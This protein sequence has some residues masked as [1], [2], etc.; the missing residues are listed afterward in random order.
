MSE[1]GIGCVAYGCIRPVYAKNRGLCKPH[2]LIFLRRGGEL[3]TPPGDSEEWR[4]VPGFEGYYAASDW[5]R[6]WSIRHC[7]TL[8]QAQLPEGYLRVTLCVEKRR[9]QLDVHWVIARTFLGPCPPRLQVLH[10]DNI[11]CHNIPANLRYGTQA[12]NIQQSVRDGTHHW[13]KINQARASVA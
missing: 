10:G 3:P 12:E 4:A 2:H 13:L 6:V 8:I 9:Y 7:R 5:G 1:P 11:R